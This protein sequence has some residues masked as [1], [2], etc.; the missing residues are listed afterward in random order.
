MLRDQP[1]RPLCSTSGMCLLTSSSCP[2][3]SSVY[4]RIHDTPLPFPSPFPPTHTK[5]EQDLLFEDR[6]GDSLPASRLAFCVPYNHLF[7]QQTSTEHLLCAALGFCWLFRALPRRLPWEQVLSEEAAGGD[8]PVPLC[9]C[10][11]LR[12]SSS[13]LGFCFLICK[14]RHWGKEGPGAPSGWTLILKIV[15]LDAIIIM[16]V[17]RWARGSP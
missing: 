14:M 9:H 11:A 3:P 16:L 5:K 12:S 7:S 8:L 2:L 15:A 10:V 13:S 17:V 4:K 6:M 1:L